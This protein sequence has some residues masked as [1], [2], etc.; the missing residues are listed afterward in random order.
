MERID[1]LQN[2]KIKQAVKLRNSA[3]YRREIGLFFSEGLRLVLDAVQWGIFP[4]TVFL[5]E[6]FIWEHPDAVTALECDET[7]AFTVSEPVMEKLCDTV[8]PQGV[9]ALFK[10]PQ[11]EFPRNPKG[12]YIGLENTQDPSNLGAIARSAEAFGAA[13]LLVSAKGC[14]PFAPK[15][16]RAGMGALLRLPMIKAEDFIGAIDRFKDCGATVFAS[17][18]TKDALPIYRAKPSACS[19]L[20]IGNEAGGLSA[21]AIK[22]SDHKV[23][24]PMIGRAESLNAAA[25]SAVLVYELQKGAEQR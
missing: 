1:S 24:I 18:V 16:L 13:G 2:P 11:A 9:A 25:A 19:L 17:V 5:T 12:L 7:R 21:D 10:M 15:A 8:S 4:Q 3:R 6:Q 20:L 23:T 22:K 14:D